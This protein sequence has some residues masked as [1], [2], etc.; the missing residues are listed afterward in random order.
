MEKVP[1][2][3]RDRSRAREAERGLGSVA[4]EVEKVPEA[5]RDR[6]REKGVEEE[7][8]EPK[9][10]TDRGKVGSESKEEV[11]VSVCALRNPSISSFTLGISFNTVLFCS[12]FFSSSAI[13]VVLEPGAARAARSSFRSSFHEFINALTNASEGIEE[14]ASFILP[15]LSANSL[16]RLSSSLYSSGVSL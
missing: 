13:R 5:E 11:E 1:E 10:E 12:I 16:F 15:I 2:A 4:V 9:S 6:G 7:E 8:E 3:E 14:S